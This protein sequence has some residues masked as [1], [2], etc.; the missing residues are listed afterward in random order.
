VFCPASPT[1]LIDPLI[2]QF[3]EARINAGVLAAFRLIV[4]S[5]FAEM[6]IVVKF[7][8]PSGGRSMTESLVGL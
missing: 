3:P 8:F 6:F 5:T 4:I 7:S 1:S 2:V